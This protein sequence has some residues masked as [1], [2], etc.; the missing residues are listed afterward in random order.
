MK[1]WKNKLMLWT[2]Y[3]LATVAAIIPVIVMVIN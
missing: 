3:A 1:N 2:V